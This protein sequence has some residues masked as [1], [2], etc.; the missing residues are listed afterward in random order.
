MSGL[1][2]LM[3]IREALDHWRATVYRA[4]RVIADPATP[5]WRK[6]ALTGCIA[7]LLCP[8]DLIPD[9]IPVIGWAD[10]A[11]VVLLALWL[12]RGAVRTAPPS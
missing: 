7:Y 4:R 9:F 3:R 5:R 10:D 1:L 8:V 2:G 11:L 12:I 6:I